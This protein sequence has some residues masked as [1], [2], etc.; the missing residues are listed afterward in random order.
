MSKRM[1][2][3]VLLVSFGCIS[4]PL[5]ASTRYTPPPTDGVDKRY[6]AKGNVIGEYTY[7]NGVLKR[8]CTFNDKVMIADVEYDDKGMP[9]VMRQYYANGKL[10][11]EV[12]A[13]SADEGTSKS[14][15]EDGAL[16]G[17]AIHGKNG[18]SKSTS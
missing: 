12:T 17:E 9:V 10:R 4:F 6:D 3:L 15:Y 5:L 7:A 18:F 8:A 13:K 11:A 1:F 14:Y 16:E 2:V